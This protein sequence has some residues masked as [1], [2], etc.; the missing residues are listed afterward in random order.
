MD[1]EI[2]K[3]KS[4]NNGDTGL[5]CHSLNVTKTSLY[6]CEKLGV[7]EKIKNYV[8]L[9]C[10]L[11]DIGKCDIDFQKS[12]NSE[13]IKDIK[14]LRHN[15]IGYVFLKFCDIKLNNEKIDMDLLLN[16]ILYHHTI[17]IDDTQ[18]INDDWY[19]LDEKTKEN[20]KSYI[21]EITKICEK[22]YNIKISIESF[23][24]ISNYSEMYYETYNP[25]STQ[26]KK[27]P[28]I[29][30]IRQILISSDRI[31][32]EYENLKS[33]ISI[34]EYIKKRKA[35]TKHCN[36][37]ETPYFNSFDNDRYDEQILKA[38]ECI[39]KR[40]N[41]VIAS[42]GYGKT[43]LGY[44]WHSILEN[45][46]RLL[47]VCPT[48]DIS[49]NAYH[50]IISDINQFS[51]DKDVTVGLL[52]TNTWI[53]G[54]EDCDIIVTNIDNYLRPTV[55]D[56]KAINSVLMLSSNVVFDEFHEFIT[57]VPLFS[58]FINIMRIRHRLCKKVNTLLLSATPFFVNDMW[59]LEKY[60]EKIEETQI[61]DCK[62]HL[63]KQKYEIIFHETIPLINTLDGKLFAFNSINLTQ[64]VFNKQFNH[65][66]GD[67][68][69]HSEYLDDDKK[70]IREKLYNN[71]GKT[72]NKLHGICSTM[73]IMTGT[74][75]T[76]NELFIS[77]NNPQKF[78]QGV[79]REGRFGEYLD[80]TLTINL[81]DLRND[82]REKMTIDKIYYDLNLSDFWLDFLK[83]KYFLFIK[84][85]GYIT[86]DELYKI[87][88]DFHSVYKKLI[89]DYIKKLYNKSY[90]Y[91]YDLKPKHYS[92]LEDNKTIKNNNKETLR[93]LNNSFYYISEIDNSGVYC[94]SVSKSYS[95]DDYGK[96][97]KDIE[98]L[99]NYTHTDIINFAKIADKMG[100]LN[101]YFGV[102]N[103]NKINKRKKEKTYISELLEK[104]RFKDTPIIGAYFKYNKIYGFY[105]YKKINE[106]KLKN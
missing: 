34:E 42:A 55:K 41:I 28:E 99:K 38:K 64:E 52:L 70:N 81:L 2:I 66:T 36:F 17:N 93:G 40:T 32:S 85:K 82:K 18:I 53:Y 7:N 37:N 5:L 47:W 3:S 13:N 89:N 48:N 14:K 91:W 21:E 63:G 86:N 90:E 1:K 31:S 44:L 51:H 72:G 74:N 54:T 15:I 60:D 45:D 12:L 10:L 78:I 61:I 80:K 23:N 69:Y 73:G 98:L 59:D 22:E 9:C 43:N 83:E 84:E 103:I 33:S 57:S 35:K 79:G 11:H 50:S 24:D 19:T 65:D 102:D 92:K 68:L 62:R 30:L 26:S 87:Y 56:D 67:I 101:D 104:G 20:I 76:S 77:H 95:E 29:S 100:K 8:T 58:A 16:P 88:Y 105:E 96:I 49:K 106:Y 75:I 94:E 46:E 6:Y 25:K 71:N 39:K 4:L 27:T 97:N